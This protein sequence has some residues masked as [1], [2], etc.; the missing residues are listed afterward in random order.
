MSDPSSPIDALLAVIVKALEPY[1]IPTDRWSAA[2]KM[3][4]A[5]AVLDALGLEQVGWG[6]GA[7]A[8]MDDFGTGTVTRHRIFDTDQPVLVAGCLSPGKETG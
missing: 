3:E 2:E 6:P 8:T 4:P 5:R 1:D 7:I